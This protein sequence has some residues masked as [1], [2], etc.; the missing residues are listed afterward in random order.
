ML[1]IKLEGKVYKTPIKFLEVGNQYVI[2]I[3]GL[4][5]F[6]NVSIER[7]ALCSEAQSITKL[8]GMGL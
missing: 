7:P 8:L 3:N 6:I 2:E 5:V 1:E 4:R